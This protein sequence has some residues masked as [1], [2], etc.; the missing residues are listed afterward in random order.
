MISY[1]KINEVHLEISS[2]CNARCPLCPRNFRGYPYNDGYTETNLTL[3]QCQ[4][5][6]TPKFLKQL[7]RIWINGNFGDAV[8]NPETPEIINYFNSQNPKLKLE[9]STNGSARGKKYWQALARK[10]IIYFCLDGLADTHHL[11]RQNTNW[12]TIISNAKI[13]IEAGGEAVWKMIKFNHNQH[14]IDQCRELSQKLGF[15][16]FELIDQG[17]DIG[18]VFDKKGKLLHVIGEYSDEKEF[19]ILFHKKKT[20][21]VLLEDIVVDNKPNINCYSK[22]MKSIYISSVGEVYPCCFTGFNPKTY[23]HGEYLQVVNSQLAPIIKRNSALEYSLT[24]CIEWFSEIERSWNIE[25]FEDGRLVCCND[26]CG[27]A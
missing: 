24:E 16:K 26:N 3:D 13:F 5:I 20:D 14:Q 8:M 11:Y 22:N 25:K 19:K 9:I 27:S 10:S 7:N 15:K 12:H 2:L 18:P 4:H 21:L 23:G 6:F 1:D 17:R